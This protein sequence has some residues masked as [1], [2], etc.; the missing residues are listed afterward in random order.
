MSQ[1]SDQR[2]SEED[3]RAAPADSERKA[4]PWLVWSILIAAAL[5]CAGALIYFLR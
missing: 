1:R 5:L 2:Q 3:W 4:R